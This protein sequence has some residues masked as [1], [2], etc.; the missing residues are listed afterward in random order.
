MIW[1]HEVLPGLVWYVASDFKWKF[2]S[3]LLASRNV[4][5]QILRVFLCWMAVLPEIWCR[6]KFLSASSIWMECKRGF[7]SIVRGF[8]YD[9]PLKRFETITILQACNSPSM[10]SNREVLLSYLMVHF[11]E[12]TNIWS[13]Q[14]FSPIQVF[15]NSPYA[16]S[17]Q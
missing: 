10:Y 6:E 15:M 13:M 11:Q 14:F 12:A 7:K 3:V 8:N 4:T 2:W 5:L 16:C 1:G 9:H 17:T